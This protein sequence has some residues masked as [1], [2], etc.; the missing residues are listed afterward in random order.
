MNKYL[1]GKINDDSLKIKLSMYALD[2]LHSECTK[3]K[4]KETGGILVG[5][6]VNDGSCVVVQEACSPPS[7]SIFRSTTFERGV[8]GVFDYLKLLWGKK[9]K[10]YYIGEW[11]YHPSTVIVPSATDE[12]E[13]RRISQN[14]SYRCKHPL[15][16]IGGKT[17]SKKAH[18][19]AY[20]FIENK[21]S[22]FDFGS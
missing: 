5:R 7:D 4:D 3:A 16:I 2:Q 19:R 17:K 9:S 6:Y 11:H 14:K 8:K 22:E 13:M 20:V 1:D 21:M 18:F 15:M 12:S 10:V